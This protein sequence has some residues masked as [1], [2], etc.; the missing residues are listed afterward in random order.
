MASNG[1]FPANLPV[2]TGKNYNRW[3]VQMKALFAFQD[4]VDVIEN[5]VE[6]PKESASD[7]QK[8]GYKDLKKKDGKALVMLHQCVDDSHFEKI[9]GASTAKEAWDILNKAYAGAE[10]V[11]KVRLQTLR[12]QYEL[13]QM[14][15]SETI[16]T[17]LNRLQI[18]ANSIKSCGEKVSDVMLVEKTLRTLT[19]RFDHI[20]V[21][22]EESKDLNSLTIDD[23]QSSL[24]AHEQ[25]LQERNGVKETEQAL[26][27]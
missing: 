6:I 16:G 4:L 8:T 10:K 1:H 25:R 18:L 9:A 20:V 3:N 27:A 26:Q 11:K 15:E 21:A 24:E 23:L 19:P 13:L 22:I 2:L 7:A 17:Y 5:G 14:E 12:R